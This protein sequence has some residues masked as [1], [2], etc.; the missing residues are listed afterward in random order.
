MLGLMRIFSLSI[1][2]FSIIFLFQHKSKRNFVKKVAPSELITISSLDENMGICP[3]C[4][5]IIHK[6][7]IISH[8]IIDNKNP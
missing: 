4:S 7:S 5:C 2:L 3:F 8:E 1:I 6:K